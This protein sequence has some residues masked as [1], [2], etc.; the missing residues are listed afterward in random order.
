MIKDVWYDLDY[1]DPDSVRGS[2]TPVV[3]Y[4]S[5]KGLV[6]LSKE[7]ERLVELEPEGR[8][9]VNIEG[10]DKV[11]D[12]PFTHIEICAHPLETKRTEET[13]EWKKPLIYIGFI[14]LVV[15]LLSMY[16]LVRLVMDVL[17]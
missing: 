11:F 10:V 8:Y 4:T 7:F 3:L 13:D 1:E 6:E 2:R 15:G 9:E 14:V 16:G 17:N 12:L 5:K